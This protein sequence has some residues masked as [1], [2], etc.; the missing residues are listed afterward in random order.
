M[1]QKTNRHA[2]T[3]GKQV[4][5]NHQEYVVLITLFSPVEGY[6]QKDVEKFGTVLG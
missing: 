1:L 4:P 2:N 6:Y 3:N 5:G